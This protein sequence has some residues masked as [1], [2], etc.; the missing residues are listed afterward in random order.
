MILQAFQP[1]H[2]ESD[3]SEPD[4]FQDMLKLIFLSMIHSHSSHAD[5]DGFDPDNTAMLILT[6]QHPIPL[7]SIFPLH[8]FS[9]RNRSPNYLVLVFIAE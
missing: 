9:C 3:N 2:A 5:K 4:L 8:L 6:F 7:F 1:R